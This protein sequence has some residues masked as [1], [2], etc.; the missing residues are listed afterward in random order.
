MKLPSAKNYPKFINV[1]DEKYELRMV[2]RIPGSDKGDL[3]M[4]DDGRKIIWIRKNQSQMGIFRTFIHEIL[5][6]CEC[7]HSIKIKH[8]QIYALELALSALIVDNL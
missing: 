6:A 7:E 8:E 1:N 4:C 2:T 3:G 5:H